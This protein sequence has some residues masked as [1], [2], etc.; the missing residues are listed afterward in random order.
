MAWGG[1][2]WAAWLDNVPVT[3]V[4]PNGDTLHLFATG[5]EFYHYV[6]DADGYTIL[7]HPVTGYY[8]YA[9]KTDNKLVASNYVYGTINPSAKGMTRQLHSAD[10]ATSVQSFSMYI[11]EGM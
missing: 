10:T 4:Q 9:V 2:A 11:A 7:Q 3:V 5:D 1:A 6:H 8:V